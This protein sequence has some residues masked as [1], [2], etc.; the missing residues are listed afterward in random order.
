M[1][2]TH[3][4]AAWAVILTTAN[5]Y[6]E[7]IVVLAQTL[8]KHVSKYP[9]LV[10]YT[11][12]T[13]P[14]NIVER[15]VS[16]GCTMIA[17]ETITPKSPI[18]YKIERFTDTW[19]KLRVWEQTNY[20]RLVLLDADMLPIQNMDELMRIPLAPDWVAACHACT[21]NPQKIPYYPSNW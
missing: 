12:D 2:G 8:H 4:K 20:D 1:V 13:I 7:G 18:D 14:D 3:L 5:K 19:T 17:I 9:L 6:V 11:P 16:Y 21:C 10:L 15:L